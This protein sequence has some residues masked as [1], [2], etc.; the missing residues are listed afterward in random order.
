[1]QFNPTNY[2]LVTP[3][4]SDT[5]LL[6]QESTGN[7]KSVLVA[8]VANAATQPLTTVELIVDL[9]AIPVV[10]VVSGTQIHVSGYHADGDGGG[11]WFYYEANN[12]EAD[13]GGTVIEPDVGAGRW[14]RSY[15]GNLD[16]RWFGAKVDGTTDDTDAVQEA[17]DTAYAL[18]GATVAFP[19]GICYTGPLTLK[20]RVCLIG[21]SPQ[22][23]LETASYVAGSVLRLKTASNA[24]LITSDMVNGPVRGTS[25]IGPGSQRLQNSTISNLSFDG[26][27][28]FQTTIDADIILLYQVWGV[29]ISNC[30]FLDSRG[31][32][33]RILDCNVINQNGNSFVHAPIYGESIADSIWASVDAGGGN[34]YAAPVVWIDGSRQEAWQNT[35]A[36][37]IIFNNNQPTAATPVEYTVDATTDVFT[38]VGA[39][40]FTD[41]TPVVP[42]TAGTLP[43][44]LLDARTVYIKVLSST[45]F[46]V[47]TTRLNLS[48]GT[49]V[50]VSSAGTGTQYIGMGKDA[51]LYINGPFAKWNSL[52]A[53]RLDQHYGH[54]IWLDGAVENMLTGLSI[55]AS[56]LGNVT[57]QNGVRLTSTATK[58]AITGCNINGTTVASGGD[59]SNQSIGIYADSTSIGTI[60]SGGTVINHSDQD[61][62]TNSGVYT[63]K[64]QFAS[65]AANQFGAVNGTTPTLGTIG[66]GRRLAWLMDAGLDEVIG[67]NSQLPVGWNTSRVVVYWC[68][69][70]AGSGNVAL[71]AIWGTFAA[72]EDL[73]ASDGNASD[74]VIAVAGAQ[75]I[76]VKTV[77]TGVA[78]PTSDGDISFIRI[79]RQG[80]N[81]S[82]TLAN[83]I[84]I[85]SVTVERI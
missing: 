63:G 18:N 28:S 49:Y 58:N 57:G 73:N 84:G 61:V 45:T 21:S 9:K 67:T 80:T 75:N 59:N 62:S 56:G 48:T 64:A 52:T 35:I 6:R 25:V 51:G 1:M 83:D 50:D 3:S 43:G 47:A 54:G 8:D 70:G 42:W 37:S 14:L 44:N 60:I 13:N 16:V 41:N 31:F 79:I 36:N 55:N 10:G 38:S 77:L 66:S 5:L 82:D 15:S 74:T 32:G 17:I 29:T 78:L 53:G 72:G 39:H 7:V 24:P 27:K 26:R 20:Y 33:L 46:K 69:A 76:M 4:L 40:G 81:I 22:P 85:I 68:N 23:F 12:S 30:Q 71:A 2:P 11:G 19:S 34:G 65:F